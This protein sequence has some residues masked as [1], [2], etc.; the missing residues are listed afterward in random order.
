MTDRDEQRHSPKR[1]IGA[2]SELG[3]I[4]PPSDDTG[5]ERE[6]RDEHREF[7]C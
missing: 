7:A 6:N 5:H 3:V 2:E 1:W 4:D